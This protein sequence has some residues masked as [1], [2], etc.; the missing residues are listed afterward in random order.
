MKASSSKCFL[1]DMEKYLNDCMAI[2]LQSGKDFENGK[3]LGNSKNVVNEKVENE[4]MVNEEVT[5]GR[6]KNENMEIVEQESQVS[7]MEE[8]GEEV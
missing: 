4:K 1:N 3:R 8:K 7:K 5:N 6:V 2:T